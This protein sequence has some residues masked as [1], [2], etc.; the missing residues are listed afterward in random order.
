MASQAPGQAL[1]AFPN[2]SKQLAIG[3]NSC[4]HGCSSS[5]LVSFDGHYCI[6]D[7]YRLHHHL[8]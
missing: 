6:I 4:H 8:E 2:Y 3:E 1:F 7:Y 5:N